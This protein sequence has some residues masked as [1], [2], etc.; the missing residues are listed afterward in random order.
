M[1]ITK[2]HQSF[3]QKAG[4]VK[5]WAKGDMIVPPG[6]AVQKKTSG[7]LIAYAA[8]PGSVALSGE[9]ERNSPYVKSL[10]KWIQ[11]PLSLTEVLTKVRVEV[12]Q[13][14]M[15]M[16]EP[17]YSSA[18]NGQFYFIN[19]P[20]LSSLLQACQKHLGAGRLNGGHM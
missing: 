2:I 14:I 6:M 10:M 16:Q 20:Q 7:S 11:K 12:K 5:S 1:I 4:F 3:Q 9:G 19:K 13:E 18:L 8:A 15:E 17:E